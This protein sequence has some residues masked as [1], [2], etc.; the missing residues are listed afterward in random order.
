[1]NKSS[2]AAFLCL[3]LAT[4][5]RASSPTIT[6]DAPG[7]VFRDTESP[8]FKVAGTSG[9][10]GTSVTT[11]TADQESQSPVA[12]VPVVADVPVV[13]SFIVRDWRGREVRQGEA[14]HDG[15]IA[16]EPLP[17]GYYFLD[18]GASHSF[19]VV[20]AIHPNPD[21]FFAADSAFTMWAK[22]GE[23]DCPWY[24]G[25]SFRVVAELMGLCG[26]SH[27][28]ERMILGR[29]APSSDVVNYSPYLENA[30]MMK[31]SGTQCL[32]LFG[33][34]PAWMGVSAKRR[35]PRD[36]MALYRF[37][38]RA[39]VEF[40]DCYDAWE[41]WNE[42]DLIA[43]AGP[44]WEYAAAL[45][46]FSLGIAAGDSAKTALPG[47]VS[48][49][50]HQGFCQGMFD[51]DIAKYV[52]A[53][54]LHTYENPAA[55]PKWLAGIRRFLAEA[56]VP[57]FQVWLTEFGT[58]LEGHG[59]SESGREGILAHSPEQELLMAE[60]CP[61]GMV[62]L[63]FGGIHRAWWFLF[64]CYNE[65][66]GEKDWGMMRRDG[67]VKPI[68]A[69]LAT[70]NAELGGAKMLGE[71]RVG[72]GMRAFLYAERAEESETAG[73]PPAPPAQTL[74][75][76]R[77]TA[78]DAGDAQ[79]R[80]PPSAPDPEIAIPA[81]DG[82][83]RIVDVMGTPRDAAAAGGTLRLT[84]TAHPQYVS[85]LSGLAADIPATPSGTFG[86]KQAES[87]ED[88]TVV[89]RP[90][91]PPGEVEI[92]GRRCLAELL[93]DTCA[94]ELE[95]WN[96]SPES[97]T[98]G[99]VA[100][101]GELRGIPASITLPPFGKA[102]IN[103]EY[104]PPDGD[105]LDFTLTLRFAADDGRVST[106]AKIPFFHRKRFLSKCEIVPW[107]ALNNT[108]AWRRNDSADEYRCTYDEAEDA[109]RFDVEW[110][111]GTIRG[112][113]FFPVHDLKLPEESM[114][115]GRMLE[116]E[117]KSDQDKVENDFYEVVVMALYA[118][119]QCRY[120]PYLRPY[121]EW[122]IRRAVV[123]ADADK[124]VALR[125]GGTPAGRRLSYWIR[126][127]RLLK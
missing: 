93:N 18:A 68:C 42:Q 63:Q 112:A 111:P 32:G 19:C 120:L 48:A 104:V 5:A 102:D 62:L 44:V 9:T 24:D 49:I 28:R 89:V 13:P 101:G 16:L 76:W 127:V 98:G 34:T 35:M 119:G 40:G 79:K 69:A 71:V 1:M 100:E 116:F 57:D 2:M 58:N 56:D 105:G 109:V 39:V 95:L 107:P 114:A 97:K 25:D 65:R 67:S 3:C 11:G 45:K 75:F 29:M 15:T 113:W 50:D 80:V 20:P 106:C 78:V 96:F 84:A 37:M 125:F 64:G 126:N 22:R 14:A 21:S 12:E 91:L 88:L 17:P 60:I 46:A 23:F 73:E 122:S 123:P 87:D 92:G 124:I 72:E 30:R 7:W 38:E 121:R 10:A 83:Y 103:A 54:N 43:A 47:S 108:A 33:D 85:G 117:V 52:D 77:E 82:N 118:D 51:N 61:K 86:R 115:G 81:A 8:V 31:R 59:K 90:H 94:I 27:T 6:T 53:F 55:F 74:V 110:K 26:V 99:V 41:F 36:L 66:H 4:G 70:L